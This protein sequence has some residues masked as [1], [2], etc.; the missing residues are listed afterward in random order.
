MTSDRLFIGIDSGTQGTKAIIFS[1]NRKKIIAE[2]Y[3]G[4]DLIEN[5]SGAREQD[6]EVWINA[7]LKILRSV[8]SSP[9]VN[10]SLV[11]A[12]GVSG[13][14]HGL[15]PLDEKGHVIRPAKLWCDTET[16][17]QC[18]ALTSAMGGTDQVIQSI[19]NSIAP[20]FTVSKILW[21]KENEPDNYD[22]LSTILL[23]HDYINYRLTGEKKTDHGDASGTA[24]YNIEKRTW[25]HEILNT[26]D[27]SGKLE[28]C[29]PELISSEKPVGY[30]T[31][32]IAESLNLPRGVI[33]S[34]GGGDNMM[35]A[36]GTGNVTS[37]V[38][39]ASLGTSGTIYA[40]SDSPVI[41]PKG[42]VAAFCS[43]SGGF[44]PLVCTMNVTVATELTRQL[45]GYDL[46][47]FNTQARK[48]EP[49]SG[50]IIL[51]PYF[52]GERT[53]ALPSA[54][55]SFHGLTPL[56]MTSP[57]MCRASM[58]GATLGLRYALEA[59]KTCGISPEEIRI[60]G[61]GAKSSLWR[62]ITADILGYPVIPT[63][64]P[65][66]GAL[67]AAIQA[68]WCLIN[69][70]EGKT[71]LSTLTDTYIQLDHDK[72]CI[73]VQKNQSSYQNL[74]GRYLEINKALKPV[75]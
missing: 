32:Q 2:D 68:M 31:D 53:P 28:S 30:L 33:V 51:I 63:M 6:P 57:N 24:Y 70:T 58:E 5:Q 18:K 23:P 56:N 43:S 21:L 50:G 29:L 19:G 15:V 12:I 7:C 73:P 71:D 40:Y 38:V 55:A 37:G 54:T 44:L 49:G 39:T 74:Y 46:E 72:R 47:H 20:G 35:A 67:G 4:Y 22:K 17:P 75:Y 65:E 13:Q 25:A 60:T 16:E 64:N 11:T 8:L 59:L 62:Q 10:S 45:F 52:N 61:G 26:I 66:A 48:S 9:E 3:A 34:S 41:D 27:P 1:E 69:E 14:Q 36:I 42:E